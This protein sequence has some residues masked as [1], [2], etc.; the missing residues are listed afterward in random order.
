MLDSGTYELE[1]LSRPTRSAVKL[2]GLTVA[3]QLA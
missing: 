1:D 3:E 2:L